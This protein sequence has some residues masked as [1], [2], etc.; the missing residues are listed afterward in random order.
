MTVNLRD[1][2]NK[3]ELSVATV[4]RAL[5]NHPSVNPATR[6]QILQAAMEMGYQPLSSRAG[7][8]NK[9]QNETLTALAMVQV[10]GKNYPAPDSMHGMIL[11]GMSEAAMDLDVSLQIHYVRPEDLAGL[12]QGKN[13]PAGI[14]KGQVDGLIIVSIYD[15]PVVAELAKK[16]P[17]VLVHS[18]HR[19][20]KLDYVGANSAEAMGAMVEHFFSLGHRRIGYIGCDLSISWARERLSGY[21]EAMIR[22]GLPLYPEAIIT[23]DTPMEQVVKMVGEGVRAWVC[24]NDGVGYQLMRELSSR[25]IRVPED[26]SITGFDAMTKPN[27]CK[28]LTSV[29]EPCE[30]VGNEALRRLV[31]RIRFPLSPA[32]KVLYACEIVEG[33]T[34][35]RNQ[36]ER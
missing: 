27:D 18:Y 10:Y 28:L 13:E 8:N 30:S 32:S 5:S 17:C 21:L 19:D 34:D 29:R 11:A 33:E 1:I 25:G 26:V 36:S 31:H 4:S 24:A 20:L 35:G 16:F 3:L 7:K 14:R 6:G 12:A 15:Q 2:A 23:N 22:L 9:E